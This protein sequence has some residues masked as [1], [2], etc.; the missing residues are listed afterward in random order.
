M[1]RKTGAVAVDYCRWF[2]FD[3]LCNLFGGNLAE[4]FYD[5]R[6]SCLACGCSPTGSYHSSSDRIRPNFNPKVRHGGGCRLWTFVDRASVVGISSMMASTT[7]RCGRETG[8]RSAGF[9]VEGKGDCYDSVGAARANGAGSRHAESRDGNKGGSGRRIEDCDWGVQQ[10][11]V[12]GE[13]LVGEGIEIAETGRCGTATVHAEKRKQ[14][15]RGH[16]VACPYELS[17]RDLLV[18]R[19]RGEPRP[20]KSPPE[21]RRYRTDSDQFS[22][23][24]FTLWRNWWAMAPSTTRWS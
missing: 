24:S 1:E 8:F 23:V 20:Y 12:G 10:G 14:K 16:G 22:K 2:P 5:C 15:R 6:D 11:F 18:G 19:G 9:Y 7:E 17:D 21:S 13:G 4:S 3:L